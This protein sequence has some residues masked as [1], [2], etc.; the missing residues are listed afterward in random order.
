MALKSLE[1]YIEAIAKP[2]HTD[3]DCWWLEDVLKKALWD[4]AAKYATDDKFRVLL[5]E[6]TAPENE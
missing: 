4:M 6:H 1:E 5:E 3:S 2:H